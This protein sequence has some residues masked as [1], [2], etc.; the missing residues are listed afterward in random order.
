MSDDVPNEVPLL[1]ARA[2]GFARGD[3]PIF[4]PLD[5]S[6]APRETLVMEGGNGAGKTTLVRVLAGLL[7]P[8]TGSIE[9]NGAELSRLAPDPGRI[10]LLGHHLAL[11]ADLT[12]RENLKFRIALQGLRTGITI[13]A[14]LR[15]TGLEGYEDV[16][17]RTLSAGQR[18][19]TALAALLLS[20]AQVWLLDEPY[21]NLDRDGQVLVDRMLEAHAARGGATVMTSHGLVRPALARCRTHALGVGA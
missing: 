20:P 11:K 16:A 10:A 14:A 13:A 12:P 18:K 21:A 7:P 9:W 8:G 4:G 17:V 19:R 15:S 5:F 1:A 3:E 2:L 6:L